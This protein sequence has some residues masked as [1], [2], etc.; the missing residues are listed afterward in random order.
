MPAS[1]SSGPDGGRVRLEYVDGNERAAGFYS[2]KGFAELRR[3]PGERPGWPESVWME[4][5]SAPGD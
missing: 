3:E 5:N 4:H 2:A 1:A